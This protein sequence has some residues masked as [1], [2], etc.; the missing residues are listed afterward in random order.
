MI[1]IIVPELGESIQEVQVAAWLK[2]E[3]EFVKKDEDLVELESEKASQALPAPESGIVGTIKVAEGEFAQVGDVLA[4]MEKADAPVPVTPDGESADDS[5]AATAEASNGSPDAIIMPAAQRM[6][7]E[8]KISAERS[9]ELG[10][11]AA[12]GGPSARAVGDAGRELVDP[13]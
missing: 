12:V 6:L 10:A 5:S 2:K 7:H 8:Y 1:E 3:G 4:L 11:L 9:A 13:G